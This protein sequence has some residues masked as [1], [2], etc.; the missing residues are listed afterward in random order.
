MK[1]ILIALIMFVMAFMGVTA[2]NATDE[3]NGEEQIVTLT[4]PSA[5]NSCANT[6]EDISGVSDIFAEYGD[7]SVLV[8]KYNTVEDSDGFTITATLQSKYY[9]L[10]NP[11]APG[12]STSATFQIVRC[13]K[14]E[15]PTAE[16][17]LIDPVVA[18]PAPVNPPL[19]P[20]P[21]PQPIIPS[22]LPT[23]KV[24]SL[25]APVVVNVMPSEA[26]TEPVEAIQAASV[27]QT[28]QLAKTGLTGLGKLG[29]AVGITMVLIGAFFV[30]V[31]R[32]GVA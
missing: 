21:A 29:L 23:L 18:P 5:L 11:L 15:I 24:E 12:R 16:P 19:L 27:E 9:S 17:V 3:P 20:V 2:A 22:P 26:V 28:P 30:A 8:A 14:I 31:G 6:P 25:P 13:E 10:N 7:E 1:K 32:K 4:V